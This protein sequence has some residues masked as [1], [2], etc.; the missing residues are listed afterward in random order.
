MSGAADAARVRC[1]GSQA[2]AWSGAETS[3]ER[4]ARARL[5]L[6]DERLEGGVC[7]QQFARQRIIISRLQGLDSDETV[8]RQLDDQRLAG[9]GAFSQCPARVRFQAAQW[10]GLD[11][12]GTP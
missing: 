2:A 8:P 1:S 11:A 7:L 4:L 6:R 3:G 10:D 9:V 5:R 12:H